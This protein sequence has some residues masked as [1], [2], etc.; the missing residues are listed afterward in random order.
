MESRLALR[1]T[2]IPNEVV[3]PDRR[4]PSIDR[5]EGDVVDR[6]QPRIDSRILDIAPNTELAL[7]RRRIDIE[8]D[9]RDGDCSFRCSVTKRMCHCVRQGNVSTRAEHALESQSEQD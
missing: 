6:D 8:H 2:W 5:P 4:C 7:L 1:C 3:H 9:L